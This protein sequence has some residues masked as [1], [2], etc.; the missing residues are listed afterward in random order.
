MY[1]FVKLPER[2]REHQ[3]GVKTSKTFTMVAHSDLFS[4]FYW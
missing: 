1:N 2:Q 4:H 3:S